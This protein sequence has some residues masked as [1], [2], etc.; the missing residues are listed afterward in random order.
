MTD[1]MT[2]Q[3]RV[4]T[5]RYEADG[6]IS[7]ELLPAPG[8]PAFEPFAPGAHIDVQLPN[9]LVRSYSLL[10]SPEEPQRYVIAVLLERQSR[11]GSRY[12][13]EQL[14]VGYVLPIS[15]P[16]NHFALR[17][18]ASRH[19][20]LAGGIG[21]TPLLCM[22]RMLAA[23]NAEVDFFYCARSR[24]QAAFVAEIEAMAGERVRVH[25][26]FDDVAGGPPNLAALLSGFNADTHFY[27]C[28]PAPMLDGFVATCEQQGKPHAFIERFSAVEA[29]TEANGS[30]TVTLQRSGR[31][32]SV[33]A[34]QSLLDAL[35]DQGIGA[36]FSCR[37]GLCGACE[38]RVI[39][40]QVAHHD[41]ILTKAE[42]EANRSMMVCVSHAAGEGL[43]LDL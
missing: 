3:A 31:T 8:S 21:V 2:H 17:A 25:T 36:S 15:A 4:R 27:A 6:V 30:Y 23:Q 34:G 32:V 35:L 37:E 24:A 11:G 41:S 26:H 10:N 14:R 22:L 39:S 43:V 13:H 40:G 42:R 12:I 29:P 16:R 38:T 1:S 9:G 19:V 18:G 5:L 20:L 28:G 33:Q 7:L